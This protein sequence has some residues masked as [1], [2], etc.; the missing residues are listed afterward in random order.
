MNNEV[1]DVLVNEYMKPSYFEW[2]KNGTSEEFIRG[3]KIAIEHVC[4]SLF[5]EDGFSIFTNKVKE[6]INNE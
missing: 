5:G 2:E 3:Y 4:L 6:K 1:L